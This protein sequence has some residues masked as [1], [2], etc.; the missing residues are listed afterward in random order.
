M[1]FIQEDTLKRFEEA[2][3]MVK[4]HKREITQAEKR[5]WNLTRFSSVFVRTKY[6]AQSFK[7][8]FRSCSPN[9]KGHRKN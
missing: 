2:E 5:M 4:K 3:R 7:N 9:M 1:H 6:P 8:G